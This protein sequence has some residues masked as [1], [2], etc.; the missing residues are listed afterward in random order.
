[1]VLYA[2]VP[3]DPAKIIRPI[4]LNQV[5]ATLESCSDVQTKSFQIIEVLNFLRLRF[6][7]NEFG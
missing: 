5:L 6:K 3:S 4:L 1:M 2:L 7:M